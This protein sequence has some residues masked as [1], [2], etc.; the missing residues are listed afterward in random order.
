MYL[1][2]AQK[3]RKVTKNDVSLCLNSLIQSFDDEYFF[4]YYS[5][6]IFQKQENDKHQIDDCNDVFKALIYIRNKNLSNNDNSLGSYIFE[7]IKSHDAFKNLQNGNYYKIL[8]Y[9]KIK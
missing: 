4:G 3:E 2:R 7:V 1:Q 6:L 8:C 9:I 5:K